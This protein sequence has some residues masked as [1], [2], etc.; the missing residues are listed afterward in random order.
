[1]P[2]ASPNDARRLLDQLTLDDTIVLLPGSD[3][4]QT[5]AGSVHLGWSSRDL[6]ATV[7]VER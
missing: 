4:W 3:N 5:P 6:L 1:M 7:D 2:P